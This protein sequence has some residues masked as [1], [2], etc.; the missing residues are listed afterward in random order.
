MKRSPIRRPLL[1]LAAAA[2]LAGA[3]CINLDSVT[4]V[5]DLRV[6]SVMADKPGF[7]V[8]LDNP[9][10]AQDADLQAVL[11]ALVID[12]KGGAQEVS[13][14]AAGCPNYLDAITA[15]SSQG[16]KLC[17]APGTSTGIPAPFDS[18]L[19]TVEIVPAAAPASVPPANPAPGT[20]SSDAAVDI[21][22]HPALPAFGMTGAQLGLFFSPQPLG[23][24]Q[25]DQAIQN[26]RD[27]GID[28]LVNITFTLGAEQA[29][30]VKRIVYWPD[31]SAEMPGEIPNQNPTIDHLEFY[32]KRDDTYGHHDLPS[33]DPADLW[34]QDMTPTV[35]ISAKDKLYVLPVPAA[36]AA[37]KYV[38]RVRDFQTREIVT[39][40]ADELLTFQFFTTAGTFSPGEQQA[41][42]PIFLGPGAPTHLDSELVLPKA[43]DLPASGQTDIW[44]VVHDERAGESWKHAVVN[45]I[46]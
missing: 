22:Y 5:K 19:A 12:P 32:R 39:Q 11:T 44:I 45:I 9:G 20:P 27:F 18:A 24:P 14:T 43:A 10:A 46:P 13:F 35:S 33:V 6:L 4:D 34:P 23:I 30:V 7:L 37:E 3:A 40:F 36:G 1:L 25:V 29:S 28:A 21:E 41:T 8:N 17:P 2:S 26:N 38:L 15:A 42:P 31:L 16:T